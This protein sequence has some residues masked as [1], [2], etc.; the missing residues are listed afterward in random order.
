M[1]V[2]VWLICSIPHSKSQLWAASCA[3]CDS[4]PL[5]LNKDEQSWD[6][7]I[8][9]LGIVPK[10]RKIGCWYDKWLTAWFLDVFGL[11]KT[12]FYSTGFNEKHCPQCLLLQ[13]PSCWW[14]ISRFLVVEK[15]VEPPEKK[16]DQWGNSSV[17][18]SLTVYCGLIKLK[19]LKTRSSAVF[20]ASS[21]SLIRYSDTSP[22]REVFYPHASHWGH[23][24]PAPSDGYAAWSSSC[25]GAQGALFTE[26]M[27]WSTWFLF[28]TLDSDPYLPILLALGVCDF[29]AGLRCKNGYN[30]RKLG[31]LWWK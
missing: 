21:P 12:T 17:I 30:P 10:N 26:K 9:F 4:W 11:L 18:G 28:G 23:S 13:S 16:W 1:C 6:T 31:N 2:K 5:F 27:A 14:F 22:F 3:S 29:L 19:P 15:H 8:F 7:G 20:F 25:P 24:C